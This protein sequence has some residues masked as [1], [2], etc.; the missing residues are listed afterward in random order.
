MSP[1]Y[2]QLKKCAPCLQAA[3]SLRLQFPEIETVRVEVEDLRENEAAW[4][5][6][7]PF[8]TASCPDLHLLEVSC[9][10]IGTW[11]NDGGRFGD[12]IVRVVNSLQDDIFPRLVCRADA[13]VKFE[14][15]PRLTISQAEVSALP[16]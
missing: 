1:V 2:D 8:L 5:T 14:M 13:V 15:T 6:F 4:P 3:V 10:M 11:D 12:W 7:L 16:R 9:S